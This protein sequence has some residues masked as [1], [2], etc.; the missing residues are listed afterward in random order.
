M[1][2]WLIVLRVW[3]DGLIVGSRTGMLGLLDVN[4]VIIRHM[5]V[6]RRWSHGNVGVLAAHKS[7]NLIKWLLV[8][9]KHLAF[10]IGIILVHLLHFHVVDHGCSRVVVHITFYAFIYERSLIIIGLID[11]ARCLRSLSQHIQLGLTWR[12]L[13]FRYHKVTMLAL[14]L[15]RQY[16]LQLIAFIVLWFLVSLIILRI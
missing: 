6:D 10:I 9:L 2:E 7:L 3:G 5:L 13:V 8:E 12:L 15:I 4:W 16:L 14:T 11:L 1:N